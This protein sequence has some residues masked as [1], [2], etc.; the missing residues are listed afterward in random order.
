MALVMYQM[1]T[2]RLLNDATFARCNDFDI[3]D[4]VNIARR[5]VAAVGDCLPAYGVLE[6]GPETQQ[7][8]FNEIQFPGDRGIVDGIGGALAIR[9]LLV[10]AGEG[11][12][13]TFERAWPWFSTYE[14]GKVHPK[15]ERP[16]VWSQY[17]QGVSGS[18]F[19]N[20][21]D[22]PYRVTVDA[23]AYPIDL[24]DDTTPEAVPALWTDAIP[25][26][27]AFYYLQGTG[28]NPQLAAT[29]LQGFQAMMQAARAGATP[30]VQAGDFVGAP[31]PFAAN[32]FGT[33]VGQLGRQPR[34]QTPPTAA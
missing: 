24:V 25:F 10:Q 29:M 11:H 21:L 13:R 14:L 34:Q 2:R 28:Q 5:Q 26:F 22:G 4:Y 9:T 27:A 3:R 19:F 33:G 20:K 6:V 31:D 16:K 1:L 23:R 12:K 18:I 30:S 17:G 8:S 32:R 15:R 7:Y